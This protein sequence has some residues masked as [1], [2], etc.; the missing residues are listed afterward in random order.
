MYEAKVGAGRRH[1]AS[2]ARDRG[3]EEPSRARGQ[4]KQPG[5]STHVQGAV[6]PLAQEGLEELSQVEGQEGRQ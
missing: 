1:P 5:R 6:A 2:K 3:W 4:G